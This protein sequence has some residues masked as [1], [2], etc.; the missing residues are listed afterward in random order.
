MAG[1]HVSD[2]DRGREF[3]RRLRASLCHVD[4]GVDRYIDRLR[5]ARPEWKRSGRLE[6]LHGAALGPMVV[7]YVAA[8]RPDTREQEGHGETPKHGGILL[9]V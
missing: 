1:T 8:T 6:A 9:S 4:A 7:L 5:N 2:T 3:H